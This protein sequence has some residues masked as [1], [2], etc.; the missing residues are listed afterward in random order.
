MNKDRLIRDL[1]VGCVVVHGIFF[2][3]FLGIVHWPEWVID[4]GLILSIGIMLIAI[5]Q[6]WKLR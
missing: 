1:I 6:L 2:S 5:W 4:G 3:G